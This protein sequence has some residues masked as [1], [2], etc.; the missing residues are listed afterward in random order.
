M[1]YPF[2]EKT[3]FCKIGNNWFFEKKQKVSNIFL[4]QKSVFHYET[5]EKIYLIDDSKLQKLSYPPCKNWI[6]QNLQP[7]ISSSLLF[8]I[9]IMIKCSN[10]RYDFIN[11][12]WLLH[13]V[14]NT[15]VIWRVFLQPPLHS[16]P[17][18][19]SNSIRLLTSYPKGL[20]PKILPR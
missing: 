19:E 5:Y 17:L 10:A 3:E 18:K 12:W 7:L 20:S 6:L 9:W 4:R 14:F 15:T 16:F 2:H 13:D 1:S 11:T 8:W